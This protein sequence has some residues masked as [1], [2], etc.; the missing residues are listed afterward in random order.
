MAI[1]CRF[2]PLNLTLCHRYGSSA[3]ISIGATGGLLTLSIR[4]ESTIPSNPIPNPFHLAG[5]QISLNFADRKDLHAQEHIEGAISRAISLCRTHVHVHGDSM[6]TGPITV[7]Y[8]EVAVGVAPIPEPQPLLTW[9]VAV[10][11]FEVIMLKVQMEG[12]YG[13]I[14]DIWNVDEDWIGI[15][16]L[17]DREQWALL[18]NMTL[19]TT[20]T[21]ISR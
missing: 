11:I 14:G 8:Q 13:W 18:R 15:F 1:R 17:D 3:H 12:Y 4:Q 9:T 7:P 5:G 19:P 2:T 16:V 10:E 6:L 21:T 20:K